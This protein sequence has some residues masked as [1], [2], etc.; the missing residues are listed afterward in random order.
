MA[1]QAPTLRAQ[2]ER[3][4]SGPDRPQNQFG[5]AGV[6]VASAHRQE[7]EVP[8][9]YVDYDRA[10]RE[11]ELTVAQTVLR[12]HTRVADLFNDPMNQTEQQLRLTIQALRERQEHE[13]VNN[14]EIG[15]LHNA[16]FP[17]RVH[18]RTGPPTPD[19]FDEL[20]SVV[21][22]NPGFF[23]A[24]PRTIAAF[25]RECNR[26][27]LYPTPV[28]VDGH[29]VPAWRGIPLLPC[30]KIPI[31]DRATSSVMLMR[32]GEDDRGVVGLHQAGIPD[33]YEPSLSVR[34]MRMDEK[35]IISYLVTIYYSAA[36]LVPDALGVLEDVQIGLH[37]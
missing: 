25:A 12:V 18:S 34:F 22:K 28:E 15:L 24:H 7:D 33:E 16:A 27:G 32:V 31:T 37:D 13:M 11:Y 1:D 14:P 29:T 3:F 30:N 5:E 35:G 23:F 4:V 9:T 21:W 20:L 2:I 8:G 10:P 36:V 6:E 17:Q 19:D 26:R